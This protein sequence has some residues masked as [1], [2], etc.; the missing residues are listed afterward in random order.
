VAEAY[1]LFQYLPC[2]GS[3]VL[4]IAFGITSRIILSLKERFSIFRPI[5]IFPVLEKEL[6][7]VSQRYRHMMVVEG[8]DGQYAGWAEWATGRKAIRV[9]C[10]GGGFKLQWI[11]RQIEERLKEERT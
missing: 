7:E 11:E 1:P 2:R 10:L 5:R 3:D 9:P 6:K 8:S 4:L